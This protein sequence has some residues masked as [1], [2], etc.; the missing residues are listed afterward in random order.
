MTKDLHLARV[1]ITVELLCQ[2]LVCADYHRV[3][4]LPADAKFHSAFFD[5]ETL[6]IWVV[7]EHPSFRLVPEGGAIPRLPLSFSVSR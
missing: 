7:F 6:G 5:S 1:Q 2:L 3:E 4:G